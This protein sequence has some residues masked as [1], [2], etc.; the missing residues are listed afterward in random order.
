MSIE[1]GLILG[2]ESFF[3]SREAPI[4]WYIPD[5][6]SVAALPD[7]RPLWEMFWLNRD[8]VT[9]FAHTHP[10]SGIPG[11][12]TTDL[13]TFAAIEAGLGTRLN[14]WILSSD[15]YVLLRYEGNGPRSHLEHGYQIV[16]SGFTDNALSESDL[17]ELGEPFWMAKL[18]R[19]S[20]Y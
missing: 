12:S 5:D 2:R 4:H 10:G 3:D 7:S 11:P 15:G 14:W 20:R 18:R 6:P 8:R 19:L 9:G 16:E 17:E 13:T 1:V